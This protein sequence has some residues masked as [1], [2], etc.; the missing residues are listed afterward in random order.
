MEEDTSDQDY[1]KELMARMFGGTLTARQYA[2]LCNMEQD[3]ILKE[4]GEKQDDFTK[5]KMAKDKIRFIEEEIESFR[6]RKVIDGE[7][8]EEQ[9]Y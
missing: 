7:W 2:V 5:T 6:R 8:P 9:S 1:K 3:E 4:K